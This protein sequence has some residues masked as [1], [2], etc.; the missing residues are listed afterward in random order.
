[1]DSTIGERVSKLGRQCVEVVGTQQLYRTKP[2]GRKRLHIYVVVDLH[3]RPNGQR[4]GPEHRRQV[5]RRSRARRA[6]IGRS[7]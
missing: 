1:M 4:Q 6:H 2:E 5:V 7:G 3:L